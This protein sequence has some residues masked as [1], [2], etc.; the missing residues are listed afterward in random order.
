MGTKASNQNKSKVGDEEV[1]ESGEAG[2]DYELDDVEG[3]SDGD[4]VEE[5]EEDDARFDEEGDPIPL[6]ED[7]EEEESSV[8][9]VGCP[10]KPDCICSD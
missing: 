8:H 5:D 1:E 4:E 2:L 3:L 6:D 10:G 9:E 7:E